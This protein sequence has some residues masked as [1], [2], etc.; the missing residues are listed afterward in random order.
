[1]GRLS[2]N[3]FATFVVGVIRNQS[4]RDGR[5]IREIIM[6]LDLKAIIEPPKTLF[7]AVNYLRNVF[8]EEIKEHIR[9]MSKEAMGMLNFGLGSQVRNGLGLNGKNPKLIANCQVT[10]AEEASELILYTLWLALRGEKS[11]HS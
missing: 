1:M 6:M 5:E 2:Y 10:N 3:S 8:S 7:C 11:R 9:G 4:Q